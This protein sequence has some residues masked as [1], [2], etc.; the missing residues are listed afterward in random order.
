MKKSFLITSILLLGLFICNSYAVEVTLLGPEKYLR[1]KGKP[2]VYT[3]TFPGRTGVGIIKVM[4]G[5]ANGK[6]R[7]SSAVILI[8]GTEILGSNDFNQFVYNLE[9]PVNLEENNTISVELRS[10]PGCYIWVQVN[11]EIEAEG[12]GVIGPEGGTIEIND[13]E[14]PI[15]GAKIEIPQGAIPED[16]DIV[17]FIEPN[18]P[19]ITEEYFQPNIPVINFTTSSGIYSFSKPINI[20]IPI[21]EFILNEP[22]I[23]AVAYFNEESDEW[24]IVH[25]YLNFD[26]KTLTFTTDHFSLYT[27]INIVMN[28]EIYYRLTNEYKATKNLGKLAQDLIIGEVTCSILNEYIDLFKSYKEN[29]LAIMEMYEENFQNCFRYNFPCG[30]ASVTD[31][32]I[33]NV[34][35]SIVTFALAEVAK[36]AGLGILGSTLIGS[37][38]AIIGTPCMI[39]I[40][41]TSTTNPDFWSQWAIYYAAEHGMLWQKKP[42]KT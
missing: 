25:S 13:S 31:W 23:P 41:S 3:G 36:W 38:G 26:D 1:T 40:L 10:K 17:I 21:N 5:D 28:P 18:P 9:V 20:T 24:E 2:N 35:S 27:I 22:K 37:S 33:E 32:L 34:Q 4:N 7:I 39:C 14:S 12:A 8:N 6:N 29:S 16:I 30:G 15:Y 19:D 11:Q 42:K